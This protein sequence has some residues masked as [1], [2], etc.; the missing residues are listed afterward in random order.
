MN[1]PFPSSRVP[2]SLKR[3]ASMGSSEA[4][5]AC[6]FAVLTA[7]LLLA[8]NDRAS[9]STYT[10][11]GS[12]TSWQGSTDW[13]PN[14]PVGGPTSTDTAE[15]NSTFSSQPTLGATAGAAGA[16]WATTG[17]GQDV[18]IGGTGTLTLAG[19]LTVNGSANTAILLDDGGNHNLTFTAPVATTSA[20]SFIVNNAGTLTLN[21]LTTGA[22][23]TLGSATDSANGTISIGSLS[24]TSVTAASRGTVSITSLSASSSTGL[25]VNSPG[26]V[27]LSGFTATGTTPAS[28]MTFN[29]TGTINLSGTISQGAGNDTQNLGTV[30]LTGGVTANR[31][32]VN[33]GSLIF[34]TGGSLSVAPGSS[35]LDFQIG[36]GGTVIDSIAN[37]INASNANTG[38]LFHIEGGGSAYLGAAN[39]ISNNSN[40]TN[41]IGN[42]NLGLDGSVLTIG[43]GAAMG[44]GTVSFGGGTLISSAPMT[45]SAS[46]PVAISDGAIG[47]SNA[48]T[49]AGAVVEGAS[50]G[51]S[52]QI[53][54]TGGVTFQGGTITLNSGSGGIDFAGTGAVTINEVVQTAGAAAG[55]NLNYSGTNTMTLT[56][57]N[58]YTGGTGVENNGTILLDFSAAGAPTTNIINSSGAFASSGGTLLVKGAGSGATNS[59]TFLSTGTTTFNAGNTIITLNQNG[60]TAL[61]L[62]LNGIIKRNTGALLNFS[63]G[64]S[65]NTSSLV[66]NGGFADDPS[67]A[68]LG[69]WATVGSGTGLQ[70]ATVD[71]NG[72]VLAYAGGGAAGANLS[73]MT[74]ATSNYTFSGA[75]AI[76]GALAGDTLRD[77][78]G[79]AAITFGSGSSLTLNGLMNAGTGSLTIGGAANSGTVTIGS[80]NLGNAKELDITSNTQNITINSVIAGASSSV[81]YSGAGILTLAGANTY[82]GGTYLESG[83]LNVTNNTGLGTGTLTILGGTLKSTSS[84][85]AL[86]NAESWVNNFSFGGANNNTLSLSGSITL[87]GSGGVAPVILTM[88]GSS[89]DTLALTGT[90]TGT[91]ALFVTGTGGT[92]ALSG[93]NIYTGATVITGGATV[94]ANTLDRLSTTSGTGGT[95]STATFTV[96]SATGLV[97]GENVSG[98]GIAAGSTIKTISGNVITLSVNTTG[99]VSGT[100]TFDFNNS[101]GLSAFSQANLVLDNGTLVYTGAAANSAREFQIGNTTN[102]SNGTLTANGSGAVDFTATAA[103]IYGAVGSADTV[104]TRTLTLAGTNTGTN[105]LA[106]LIENN[107]YDSSNSGN[108]NVSVIKTGA[109]EWVLSNGNNT[110]GGGTVINQG[111]L[112]NGANNA[113]SQSGS[114][115][116]GSAGNSATWNLNGFNQTVS[117]LATAGTAGNQTITN[118][119]TGASVLTYNGGTSTYGGVIADGG[120]GRTLGVT[121]AGGNLTLSGTNTYIGATTVASGTLN[122]TGSLA[123]GS[124]VTVG[125]QL[126]YNTPAILTGT[127]TI[128]GSLTTSNANG[129][130]GHIAPGT[131]GAGNV[132]TLTMGGTGITVTLGAGTALDFDLASSTTAGGGVNDLIAMSGGTLSIGGSSLSPIVVNVNALG[133]LSTSGTYTLISGATT[134]TG[135]SAADFEALNIGG[136]TATFSENATDTAILLSFSAPSSSTSYYF[137]GAGSND[138][139]V[140]GNYNTAASG[141]T[142]QGTALS[143]TSNVFLNATSPTPTNTP[144][145]LNT[146][147][148][149]NS[150]NFVTG[151][152][153]LVG[154][155]T[156][157]LAATGT[158]GITDSAGVSGDTETV[159]TGVVLGSDQSW[160]ATANSTLNVT[161][162][163]SGAHSLTATG[164]GTYEFGGPNTFQGLTVGTGSDTPTL[165]LTNGSNGSATGTTTLT[166]NGGATLGG[167]GTSSGTSFAITGASTSARANV[168]VGLSSATD[169]NTSNVLTLQA[170]GASSISNANLTFNINQGAVGQGTQLNVGATAITFGAGAGSTMLTLNL[171]GAGII[172]ADSAYVL[173]AGLT[174]GGADQYTGLDLGTS[175]VNG[176]VTI[177][178]ILDSGVGGNGNLALA[179]SGVTS[180][181]YS[182]NSYLFLYQNSATGADDI[183]VEVVPEPSTWALMFGGVAMLVFWQ[184]RRNRQ[185]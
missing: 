146:A 37:S 57:A 171:Q 30:F 153:S 82:S 128:N 76:T 133:T 169:T 50:G 25:V 101:L 161:G 129:N 132:G 72:N 97:V 15:F 163:I 152:T 81:A 16:V 3:G 12:G 173:I 18:T 111:T 32:F 105:T 23:L 53:N 145:T 176:N 139:T 62:N 104:Q 177:T 184:R 93:S 168:L 120:T 119:T 166:V 108:A 182:A 183:E 124:A 61:S 157:T 114:I 99:A 67:G 181:F 147:A 13:S 159:A 20:T 4:R 165:I 80:N 86:A 8:G 130:V 55:G 156:V 131:P 126:G 100:V 51:R 2:F 107:G 143:S 52:L 158:A 45:L 43:N 84:S 38:T 138:F 64:S 35:S 164:A 113:L 1:L 40:I 14:T 17:L 27:N 115:T 48:L 24:G 179:L 65:L 70:Y 59:Q 11:A 7:A 91:Q 88:A 180:S 122:V 134:I 96:G 92:L 63:N 79:T 136:D 141:G 74:S 58:T 42:S 155:G 60:D 102:G 10:W 28:G 94:T 19:N 71:I 9:A 148:S 135:F 39:V 106:A 151:G 117:S 160:A 121:M 175:V 123:A 118:T 83:T 77:N 87:T 103:I 90:V 73:S 44:T 26:T 174:S 154:S 33:S 170:T 127:G 41:A 6:S 140:A 149:I 78:G 116:L 185:S 21:A 46:T 36:A 150:L 112:E 31:Y 5:W 54:D 110:Y 125:G 47:G 172:P 66:V 162:T 178:Q 68:I 22:G 85:I 144:A 29:S 56:A 98:T 167:N 75:Q 95:S 34:G 142:V 49:I 137:T 89:S 109:G 69:A